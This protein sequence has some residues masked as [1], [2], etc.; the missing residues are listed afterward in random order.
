MRVQLFACHYH[1]TQNDKLQAVYPRSFQ[2]IAMTKPKYDSRPGQ[3][4]VCV[5]LHV[6]C[7]NG[8]IS[9]ESLQ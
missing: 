8:E 6:R 2:W 5:D 7:T 1:F 9:I 3:K 4:N